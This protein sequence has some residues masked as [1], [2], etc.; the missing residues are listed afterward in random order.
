MQL[1][2]KMLAIK[3]SVMK[4]SC[5]LYQDLHGCKMDLYSFVALIDQPVCASD[6]QMNDRVINHSV[7]E[8]C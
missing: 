2:I 5:Q 1:I 6:E 8:N 4:L 3:Q 7:Y